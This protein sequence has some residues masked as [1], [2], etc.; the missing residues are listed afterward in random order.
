MKIRIRSKIINCACD[1]Q[2]FQLSQPNPVR[3]KRHNIC[4]E[5]A[6]W[7][8]RLR[9]RWRRRAPRGPGRSNRVRAS[10]SR[11]IEPRHAS[12]FFGR[13]PTARISH[14]WLHLPVSCLLYR[15]PALQ[16]SELL[17]PLV[18][19]CPHAARHCHQTLLTI[20]CSSTRI[21]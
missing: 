19:L 6:H 18:A 4:E 8:L 7:R 10:T 12:C 1:V 21:N 20:F 11:F 5:A 3:T 14:D 9:R 17:V 16:A 13:R 2:Q 15:Q